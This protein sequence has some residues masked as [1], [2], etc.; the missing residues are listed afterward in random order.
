MEA[1]GE[2]GD[3]LQLMKGSAPGT[4]VDTEVSGC[5]NQLVFLGGGGFNPPSS[6]S[7]CIHLWPLQASEWSLEHFNTGLPAFGKMSI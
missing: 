2:Q 1:V 4:P 7:L 5:W 3:F 6:S